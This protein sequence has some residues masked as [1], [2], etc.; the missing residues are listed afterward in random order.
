MGKYIAMCQEDC[1]IENSLKP[2]ICTVCITQ[3]LMNGKW[4]WLIVYLLKDKRMRFSEIKRAIPKVTQ[5][6]LSSQLKELV[7]D[8][9][10]ERYSHNVVPPKVEYYLSE[11][12]KQFV[13]IIEGMGS[14]GAGYLG[15]HFTMET[16]D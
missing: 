14:W 1:K 8:S 3:R 16:G 9:I 13:D 11:E 12:G 7:E 6:Y 5:A 15:K 10:L 4:K 2:D